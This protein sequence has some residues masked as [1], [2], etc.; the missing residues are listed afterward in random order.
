MPAPLRYRYSL[1]S[2]L[3]G[4]ALPLVFFGIT[5]FNLRDALLVHNNLAVGL[6]VFADL[7]FLGLLG[8]VLIKRLTPA[9]QGKIALEL[10]EQGIIDYTRN[11]VIEWS[12]VKDLDHEIG[13]NSSR[14]IIKLRHETEYGSE[15][16]IRQRWIKGKDRQMFDEVYNYFEEM[17]AL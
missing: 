9:L 5:Y 7:V 10:N 8:F 4:I 13:R 15:V 6:I 14:I 2:A 3:L 11:I 17:T 1:A 12:Y 16:V